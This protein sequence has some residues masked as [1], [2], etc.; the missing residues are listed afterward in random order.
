[1]GTV[2][3]DSLKIEAEHKQQ[4]CHGAALWGMR[5]AMKSVRENTPQAARKARSAKSQGAPKRA[6]RAGER[7]SEPEI[8]REEIV[9]EENEGSGEDKAWSYEIASPDAS[10]DLTPIVGGNLRR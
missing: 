10:S 8:E 7:E 2:L 1:M 9:Q 5:H 4:A 3:V 6:S